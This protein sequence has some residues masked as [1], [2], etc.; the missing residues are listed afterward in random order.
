MDSVGIEEQLKAL[1]NR[2]AALEHQLK[3]DRPALEVKPVPLFSTTSPSKAKSGNWLGL[4]A[5]ICFIVAAGFIIKLSVDSGW[6]SPTR[7]IGLAGLFGFVLIGTGFILLNA[8]RKYASLLPAAGIVIL[9]LTTF[10]A[11]RFY[12]LISF[13]TAIAITVLIS[14]L[15]IWLY[16]RI[17]HD[18][19]SI[20]TAIGAYTAPPILGFDITTI[21]SLYYLIV[22]SLTFA[23]I[24]IW[25]QSRTLTMISAYLAILTTAMVG[26]K[27]NQDMLIAVVLA[28]HFI[29]FSLGTYFYTQTTKQYM[30][31]TEAWSFFPVLIIFYVME[32]YFIDHSYPQWAPWVSLAFAAFL[33]SLYLSAK[34]WFPNQSLNSQS[35]ILAFVTIVTFHSLYLELL[36]ATMRP[37]LFVLII[38][39]Y[40]LF[41]VTF[42]KGRNRIFIIPS[43][44][45]FLILA[46]EYLVML[47]HLLLENFEVYWFGVST[48]S[49]LSLWSLLLFDKKLA[50]K[51]E[52][53]YLLLGAAHL[54]GITGLYQLMTDYGSLAVSA[55]WLFYAVL[56]IVFAVIRRDK[57][58]ARSA[59][60][61]L[62]FAAGKALLYDASSTPTIIRILCLLLTGIVLYG[63]GFLIRKIGE[64]K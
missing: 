63:S 22:C 13:Q 55:S 18:L 27:L 38:G 48:A 44:A 47:S 62:G 41:P 4:I 64:W 3:I 40:L 42:K 7:Q 23:T 16:V 5:I 43:F 1:E 60:I 54:L 58:M 10:A 56:V 25:V 29:I 11:H 35:V 14:T 53:G 45:I 30:T 20:L 32:Y 9:Y 26:F 28:L 52:Q 8:D 39:V 57:V 15:C 21:F 50:Q 37:W 51:E 24:S 19:Y 36:P 46:I 12:L 59:L 61:V 34:K 6:L 2:L 31:E 17:K 49:F 33:L